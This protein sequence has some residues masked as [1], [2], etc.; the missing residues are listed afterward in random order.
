MAEGKV[1]K[2][3]G[4][5]DRTFVRALTGHYDEIFKGL[6]NQPR[7]FHSKGIPIHGGP[8]GF[9]KE[10]I[11]PAFT[12][13]PMVT[14]AF[15]SHMEIIAPG[16]KMHKHG[17]MN[18]AVLYILEGKGHEIHDGER[19]NWQAGDAGI[20]RNGCVHQHFND[21]PDKPARILIIKSKPLFMFFH[22]IFQKGIEKAP[23]KP[24]PGWEGWKP[25][26]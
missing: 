6:Y 17:H 22:L 20:V 3:K 19:L 8:V 12:S 21:D 16:G 18:S 1:K 25:A 11:S 24:M 23:G 10:L 2:E 13:M 4:E 5:T 15:H 9:G 7:V 26:D 14:Q